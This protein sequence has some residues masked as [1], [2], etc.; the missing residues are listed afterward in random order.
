MKCKVSEGEETKI[1]SWSKRKSDPLSEEG[2]SHRSTKRIILSGWNA[3]L[4][5]EMFWDV[6]RRHCGLT[7]RTCWWDNLIRS[8]GPRQEMGGLAWSRPGD[9]FVNHFNF[10]SQNFNF[11]L[12]TLGLLGSAKL[13]DSQYLNEQLWIFDWKINDKIASSWTD[14]WFWSRRREEKIYR[15]KQ[16]RRGQMV[17]SLHENRWGHGRP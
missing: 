4:R 17:R 16:T 15:N 11:S 9:L 1:D 3:G 5:S 6:L 10:G 12:P 14:K 13:L 8:V 7:D 2:W